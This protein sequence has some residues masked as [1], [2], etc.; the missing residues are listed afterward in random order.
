MKILLIFFL[1]LPTSLFADGPMGENVHGR[2]GPE[3]IFTEKGQE[4]MPPKGYDR[5]LCFKANARF[6]AL[7]NRIRTIT[8]RVERKCSKGA[9]NIHKQECSHHVTYLEDI[10]KLFNRQFEV[11]S[12]VCLNQ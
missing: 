6:R 12:N 7:I 8:F 3:S 10:Y 5:D 11:M 1:I 9:G 4:P 2:Y